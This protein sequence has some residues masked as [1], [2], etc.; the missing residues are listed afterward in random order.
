[1]RNYKFTL[2]AAVFIVVMVVVVFMVRSSM[3]DSCQQAGG[4][5][6]APRWWAK[7]PLDVRCLHG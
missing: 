2:I 5:V 7:D 1:M 4:I 6:S 3:I